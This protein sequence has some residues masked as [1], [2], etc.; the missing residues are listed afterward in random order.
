MEAGQC[1][2]PNRHLTNNDV[3]VVSHKII[4]LGCKLLFFI[5][6]YITSSMLLVYMDVSVNPSFHDAIEESLL[7]ACLN[8]RRGLP[9]ERMVALLPRPSFSEGI[10]AFRFNG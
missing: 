9:M 1:R 2:Y 10:N 8:L 7:S 5:C 6:I 4:E 3:W